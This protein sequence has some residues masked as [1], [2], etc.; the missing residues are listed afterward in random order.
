MTSSKYYFYNEDNVNTDYVKKYE[1]LIKTKV[2]KHSTKSNT[3]YDD[4]LNK[5]RYALL[6]AKDKYPK[7]NRTLINKVIDNSIKN[8]YKEVKSKRSRPLDNY[9]N[10]DGLSYLSS[11]KYNPEY[12][13]YS[14]WS[15]H[16]LKS[17]IISY[18]TWQ[19]E[20]VL[21]LREQNYNNNEISRITDLSINRI[22]YLNKRIRQKISKVLSSE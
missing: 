14:N 2:G 16:H 10:I 5:A 7:R 4:Y 18:L 9:L 15:Y 12:Q 11:N 6:N 8:H 20:L 19:E 13:L 3:D 22:Y 17:T 1:Y 21:I